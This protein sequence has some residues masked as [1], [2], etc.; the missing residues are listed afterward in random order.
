[1]TVTEVVKDALG[2]GE[3][4]RKPSRYRI[5][6][7][8]SPIVYSKKLLLKPT[9]SSHQGA[10]VRSSASDTVPRQLR[11][12][13]DP[14]QSLPVRRIL[15]AVEMRGMSDSSGGCFYCP[16]Q[17]RKLR[18]GTPRTND[19]PMRNASTKNSRSGLRR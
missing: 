11:T 17:S 8:N 2:V 1:M 12:F 4:P 9:F 6:S 7:V 14:S 13:T 18:H 16:P 10:D 15:S 5:L 19:T 3:N